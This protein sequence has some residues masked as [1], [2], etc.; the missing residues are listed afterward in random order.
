[1]RGK[2]PTAFTLIEILVV[3]AV[4][5]VLLAVL[6][7]AV[8]SARAAARQASC[9]NN[10]KQIGLSMLN[11]EAAMGSFPLSMSFGE[12]HGNGHSAFTAILPY[13]DLVPLFNAYNFWLEN[14]HV[15]NHT[16]VGTHVKNFLCPDNPDVENIPAGDVRFPEPK[17]VFAKGHYGANWGGG[18]EGWNQGT[19]TYRRLPPKGGARGPWGEDFMKQRGT[20]LGVIMAVT[21]PGGQVKA[22]DGKPLARSVALAEITDGTSFTLGFVEKRDSFGWAVGGWAGGEFDVHTSPAYEG[23]DALARK[24]YSGSTHAQGPNVVFCDGSV[25]PLSPRQDRSIWYALIT[26]AGGEIVKLDK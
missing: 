19:G 3:V 23:D 24:V 15:A 2:K 13:E 20:Y 21:M 1:M 9:A 22:K 14:W 10:L 4:I 26:R 25:R 11:Y 16:V 18:H 5:G 17:T 6:F 8:Q 12:G 7:P